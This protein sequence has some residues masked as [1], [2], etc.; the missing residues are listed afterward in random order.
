MI[1]SAIAKLVKSQNLDFEET[2]EVF[3]EIFNQKAQPAQIASFL[4][5]LKMK[6]ES[7]AEIFAA[8]TVVRQRAK[9]IKISSE[10]CGKQIEILDTC[11]TG[12]SG[13]NKFNIST[14]VSFVVAASGAKVAKHGNKAMSSSCGSADILGQLGI[15][16][17]AP[18]EIMERSLM[19]VGICFLYAPL[20]HPAF[21]AVAS[22]RKEI[23]IRTIFNI[24]GPLCSPASVSHQLLGVYSPELVL[25]MA[26][27][28]KQLGTKKAFVVYGKDLKD[29]VSLTGPTKACYLDNGKIK[30]I[31][32]RPSGL[33]LKKIKLEDIT[34]NSSQE[35][36]ELVKGVLAGKKGPSR[37]IVL[38]NAAVC[39]YL[40]GK[41]KNLKKG[42]IR[43]AEII[44]S[45]KASQLVDKFREFLDKNA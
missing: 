22:I 40:L 19:E 35:S 34:S 24:L 12:G 29:E 32:L 36:A 10:I 28:L 33:G 23:K 38:A 17:E 9:K 42:V 16:I 13:V 27:V 2:K 14:A 41:A 30:K 1:Q 39:F 3:D 25:P 44:D 45:Q 8:A 5:A 37:D 15:N 11:G 21:K 31:T 20:Y 7:E 18:A 4:T 43:A 26:K 6:G